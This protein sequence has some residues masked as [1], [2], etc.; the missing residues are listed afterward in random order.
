MT[1]MRQRTFCMR[2]A[3]TDRREK[4]KSCLQRE[5]WWLLLLRMKRE[6]LL[7]EICLW[8][9]MRSGRESHRKLFWFRRKKLWQSSYGKVRRLLWCFGRRIGKI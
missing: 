1:F 6:R 4:E 5:R 2:T 8:G 3:G 9:N 7:R